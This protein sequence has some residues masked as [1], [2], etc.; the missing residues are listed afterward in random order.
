[1]LQESHPTIALA[2]KLSKLIGLD[3]RNILLLDNQ[4]TFDLCSNRNFVSL[5]QKALH[6]LN[7]TGK[8]GGLKMMEQCKI[9][10][11]KFWVWFSENAIS[12]T[13]YASR[14]S[15]RSTGSHMTAK[16]TQLLLSIE[17]RLVCLTCFLK[18]TLAGCMYA[19]QRRWLSLG[20]SRLENIT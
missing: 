19:T 15:S 20:L 1:M 7:K 10:G 6:A 9:P 14:I 16:W 8:G 11:Y 12:P 13:S 18:C 3:L 2:L 4:L 5:V 17:A